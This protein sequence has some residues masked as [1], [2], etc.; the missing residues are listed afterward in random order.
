[1]GA[2][3]PLLGEVPDPRRAQGQLCELPHVLL[4]TVLA[5]VTGCNSYRGI[6]TFIDLHRR[7]LNADFRRPGASS[8]GSIRLRWGV[9]FL[10]PP[11]DRPA[12]GR[13]RGAWEGNIALNGK[14]LRRSFDNFRGRAAAQV[15]SA[16]ARYLARARPSLDI[17]EKSNETPVAQKLLAEVGL[18][19]GTI[20]TLDA[21]HYQ[22]DISRLRQKPT[23]P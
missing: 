2:F 1:V 21:L 18:A 15:L 23:S 5:I 3:A 14:T 8:R 19:N 7:E 12:P 6:V 22:K 11:S 16:F 13:A 4:L 17:A 10:L 9:S 20:V